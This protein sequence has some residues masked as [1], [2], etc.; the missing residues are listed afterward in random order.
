MQI[1]AEVFSTA[2]VTTTRLNIAWHT[3]AILGVL[4]PLG[5]V[6]ATLVSSCHRTGGHQITVWLVCIRTFLGTFIKREMGEAEFAQRETGS[7]WGLVKQAIHYCGADMS[8]EACPRATQGQML[9][10]CKKVLSSG[11]LCSSL[12]PFSA[13]GTISTESWSNG[14]EWSRLWRV[15]AESASWMLGLSNLLTRVSHATHLILLHLF[16]FLH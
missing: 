15:G 9:M 14:E 12:L 7:H 11:V 5:L 10:L 16:F 13:I 2:S 3:P 1:H 6:R 4:K 8:M